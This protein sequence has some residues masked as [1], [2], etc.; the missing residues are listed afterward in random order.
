MTRR[1]DAFERRG[2]CHCSFGG[3]APITSDRQHYTKGSRL[4]RD[5]LCERE[6]RT[7]LASSDTYPDFD[8]TS[9]NRKMSCS[10]HKNIPRLSLPSNRGE[11]GLVLLGPLLSSVPG[12]SLLS[13]RPAP[14][15][16]QEEIFFLKS[17]E[18]QRRAFGPGVSFEAI[19]AVVQ[20][21]RYCRKI[22]TKN[23]K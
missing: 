7:P 8:V 12:W 1:P 20:Q 17:I 22:G 4:G 9:K 2:Q 23:L 10:L 11:P 6:A 3:A 5:E 14:G 16:G 15:G 21:R 18:R 19:T 13:I